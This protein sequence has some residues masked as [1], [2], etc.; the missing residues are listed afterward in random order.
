MVPLPHVQ[1][2]CNRKSTQLLHFFYYSS[3][4][5]FI[6]SIHRL[7]E[8]SSYREVVCDPLW[9]NAIVE[10]LIALHQTHT[11]DLVQLPPRKRPI[12]SR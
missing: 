11:W 6:A 2:N 10:E 8:P 9:Q 12:G 4:I 1:P 5:A 3:L 7:H